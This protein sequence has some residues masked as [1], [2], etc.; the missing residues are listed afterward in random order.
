MP[1]PDPGWMTPL[2][3]KLQNE[4]CHFVDGGAGIG[5]TGLTYN[6]VLDACLDDEIKGSARI[7]CYE[8]L[9]EN[10]V[11]MST[12]LADNQHFHLR[13]L[14]VSSENTKKT[15]VVPHRQTAEGNVWGRG[16]SYNGF[17]G[18]TKHSRK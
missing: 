10:F 12:R 5:H 7:I 1:L 9:A 3:K 16:T 2:T 14:A 15:F 13:E 8:P 17:R 6:R 11:E 4:F 18:D